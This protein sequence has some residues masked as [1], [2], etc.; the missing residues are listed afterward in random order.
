MTIAGT[1][2]LF[3]PADFGAQLA[4]IFGGL[5]PIGWVIIGAIILLVAYSIGKS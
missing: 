4:V 5:G 3:N 1:Y 2:I